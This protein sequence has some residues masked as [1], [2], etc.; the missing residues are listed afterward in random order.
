MER[1][2]KEPNETLR[3]KNTISETKRLTGK[4]LQE[5]LLSEEETRKLENVV[6][7][8]I[9]NEVLREKR[10]QKI[11]LASISHGKMSSSL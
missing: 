11:N 8:I 9:K 2:K 6:I 3:N 10:A 5:I 1:Y 7:I 4:D